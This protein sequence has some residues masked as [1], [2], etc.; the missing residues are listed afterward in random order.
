MRL[1]EDSLIDEL[2][3]KAA[4]SPRRRAHF[5]I[6]DSA[7][8]PVQRFLVVAQADAYFRPHLHRTNSE[9]AIL[10]RGRI[11][12]VTFDES[13]HVLTRQGIGEGT[14]KFAYETA[15]GTWHTLVAMSGPVAFLEVKQGPYDPATAADF[16]QWAPAEGEG[17]VPRFQRWLRESQAGS[18]YSL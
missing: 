8:D 1:F 13:G 6:H 2:A 11:D 14:G 5:N 17:S 3:A 15:R 7:A 16:A 9:L 12:L 10:L 18:L 4:A